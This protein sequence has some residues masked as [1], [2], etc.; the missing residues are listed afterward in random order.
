LA[1]ASAHSI[2]VRSRVTVERDGF[3]Q[4]RGRGLPLAERGGDEREVVG[5]LR[6][7]D[8]HHVAPPLL[9]RQ[10][11]ALPGLLQQLARAL[12]L[13]ELHQHDAQPVLPARPFERRLAPVGRGERGV[14][15]GGGRLQPVGAALAASQRQQHETEIG[16][17]PCEGRRLRLQLR[18]GDGRPQQR[19]R[20]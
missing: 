13:A 18:P 19:R 1:C 2:G 12:P 14:E 11:E 7:V 6:P 16:L 5:R 15:R 8:R 4:L 17:Q 9:Q 10:P 20:L 3:L